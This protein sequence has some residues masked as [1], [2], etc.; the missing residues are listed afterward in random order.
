MLSVFVA[1]AEREGG[2][3]AEHLTFRIHFS[4]RQIAG[5]D[6]LHAKYQQLKD[7]TLNHA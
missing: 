2:E 3:K 1:E 5:I 6:V 7:L 4:Y